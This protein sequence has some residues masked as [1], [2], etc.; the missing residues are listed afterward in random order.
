V[1]RPLW[2]TEWNNGANWTGC[3]DPT[4]AQQQAAVSKMVAMLE[5]APF[6]ERYA[7]YNWVEDVRRLEWDD[8]SLTAAGV[9]YR[10][11]ASANAYVQDASTGGLRAIM[12]FPFEGDFLDA[13][14]YF[15]NAIAV[16]CPI[17]TSGYLGQGIAFDGKNNYVQL[18]ENAGNGTS[19]SFA[20]WVYWSGG[21]DWQRIFDFGNDTSHYIFLTPRC[22]AGT[23]RFV[24]NN[25]SGEQLIETTALPTF[26]WQHV[27]VTLGGGTARLYVNG[28]Q[29]AALSG[30]T[31]TPHD[32]LPK[33][34]YLGKSQFVADPLFSGRLDEVAVNDSVFTVT[35]IAMMNAPV[36]R[37]YHVASDGSFVVTATAIPSASYAL[38]ATDFS[39][40]SA[41]NTVA[42]ATA[43]TTGSLRL[44][45]ATPQPAARDYRIMAQ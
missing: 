39:A 20:A 45:D 14:G 5:S 19:F 30:F 11:R 17:F 15:N 16:D 44:V 31:Q 42:T 33:R 8:S 35:D 25:G 7:L 12:R 26:R 10:D 9:T 13:S 3:A 28:K 32:F 18:P 21:A 37:S 40:G 34:N 27:A 29:A 23:M 43:T 24:I 38:Q 1:K 22:S 41:W 36:I 4:F 6:V 2:V